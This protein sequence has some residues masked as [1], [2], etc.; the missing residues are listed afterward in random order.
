MRT[1]DLAL[2]YLGIRHRPQTDFLW[3][4]GVRNGQ[5]GEVQYSHISHISLKGG[6]AR[7]SLLV[8]YNIP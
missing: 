6:V 5:P 8:Y 1:G 4:K 7:C 2:G 3:F